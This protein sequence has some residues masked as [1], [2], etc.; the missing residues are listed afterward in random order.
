M[1]LRVGAEGPEAGI[2]YGTWAQ[3]KLVI[4]NQELATLY[5]ISGLQL[6][7]DPF[8]LTGIDNMWVNIGR[9]QLHLPSREPAPQLLRGTLG[10]VVPNIDK[11]MEKWGEH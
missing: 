3:L 1:L 8:L 4:P 6:T 9:N 5:Y 7:R 10:I 11:Y 2:Y